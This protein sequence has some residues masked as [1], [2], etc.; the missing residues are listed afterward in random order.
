VMGL[1]GSSRTLYQKAGEKVFLL[2]KLRDK[3]SPYFSK[4]FLIVATARP[5]SKLPIITRILLTLSSSIFKKLGIDFIKLVQRNPRTNI[6]QKLISEKKS[7]LLS[8]K[9]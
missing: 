9:K 2:P 5:I 6:I 8:I 7:N 4:Q 3:F 1:S